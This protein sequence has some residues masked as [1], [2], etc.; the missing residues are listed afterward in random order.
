[1]I[2]AADKQGAGR[3]KIGRRYVVIVPESDWSTWRELAAE[4]GTTVSAT[5]RRLMARWAAKQRRNR[6]NG[7]ESATPTL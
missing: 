6:G 5:I 2:E 4:Q 3:P 7:P 1:M